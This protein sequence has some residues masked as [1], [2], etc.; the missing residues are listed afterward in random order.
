MAYSPGDD[1]DDALSVMKGKTSGMM[2][3]LDASKVELAPLIKISGRLRKTTSNRLTN[4]T[5][6]QGGA[7]TRIKKK[8]CLELCLCYRRSEQ[9]AIEPMLSLTSYAAL[10]GEGM[11]SIKSV[12][13]N[14]ED[15]TMM[16]DGF[17]V[18]FSENW[19]RSFLPRR[20]A[21]AF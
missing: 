17:K 12:A 5:R 15:P 14:D 21:N 11:C 3:P 6:R 10:S 7:P 20:S 13:C 16:V 2:C 4:N 9:V 19:R 1:H 18:F 8:F